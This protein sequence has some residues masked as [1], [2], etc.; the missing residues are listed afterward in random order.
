MAA[1]TDSMQTI[2]NSVITSMKDKAETSITLLNNSVNDWSAVNWSAINTPVLGVYTGFPETDS[3][4]K[5]A[6]ESFDTSLASISLPTNMPS[7]PILNDCT[8]P[9]WSEGSWTN[10]KTL[11]TNFTSNIT[12]N[13]DVSR[14]I[15]KLT[16]E[17]D[18]LQIALYAAD[19]ERK[20]QTLR[21]S[22]SAAHST[23]GARGFTY[24]NSMTTALKLS[25]QQQYMF[26]LSQV[27]RDLVKL[28]FEWAKD[29]YQ[30]SIQQQMA[31]HNA[32]VDFNM[33]YAN[34]LIQVF[35]TSTKV[36]LEE[37][38]SK[39]STEVEKANQ[40]IKEFALRMDITKGNASIQESK[41]HLSASHFTTA[42][43]QHIADVGKAVETA[44]ANAH[45]KI[46][47]ASAAVSGASSMASSVSQI[48]IGVANG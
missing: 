13:D 22:I 26:E 25:A 34:S 19:R 3:T 35:D 41:D 46:A 39:V 36:I 20:Q 14:V 40:K 23:T 28:I 15:S 10:L 33:R 38:R 21:D 30:F 44:A 9:N 18:K 24:P 2:I 8:T 16:N 1:T 4:I 7:V 47:A 6:L 32:D 12:S 27:S 48:L 31:A 5:T 42:V 11:L 17:T 43:N 29:N 37:Y 45:N